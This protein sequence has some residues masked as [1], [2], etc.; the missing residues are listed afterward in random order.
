[1]DGSMA[2]EWI[3]VSRQYGSVIDGASALLQ[4]DRILETAQV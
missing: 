4:G 1:M 3:F 2:T